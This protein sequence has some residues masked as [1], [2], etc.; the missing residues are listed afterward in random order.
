MNKAAQAMGR[1]G[2]GKPKNFTEVELQKRRDRMDKINEQRRA[3]FA[4]QKSGCNKKL[5][6]YPT[7]K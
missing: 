5:K 6:P 7:E 1:L 3:R 4:A 2:R